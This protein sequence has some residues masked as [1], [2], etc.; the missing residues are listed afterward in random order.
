[1]G[2]PPLPMSESQNSLAGSNH[3]ESPSSLRARP[4]QWLHVF[5]STPPDT[6]E[7]VSDV[8]TPRNSDT[9]ALTRAPPFHKPCLA[10]TTTIRN[11]TDL[12]YGN[13]LADV[14]RFQISR[15]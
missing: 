11:S 2:T 13:I 15:V 5:T 14:K 12:M 8:L 10:H 3:K 6:R 9:P 7:R 4:P 1:M